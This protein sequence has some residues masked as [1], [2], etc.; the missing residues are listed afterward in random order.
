MATHTDDLAFVEK[1]ANGDREAAEL[2]L[3]RCQLWTGQ[4]ARMSGL[5]KQEWRDIANEALLTAIGQMRRGLFRGDSSFQTWVERVIRGKIAD[6]WRARGDYNNNGTLISIESGLN[7][8]QQEV[9]RNVSLIQSLALQK[10]D[11]ELR[12]RVQQALRSMSQQQ[13]I[14][15]LLNVREG[16]STDE[17]SRRLDLPQGTVGRKLAEAKKQ[18]RQ[19]FSYTPQSTAAK[20]T[21]GK[22]SPSNRQG[23]Q[24]EKSDSSRNSILS[25]VPLWLIPIWRWRSSMSVPRRNFTRP[26]PI[27]ASA[28]PMKTSGAW[29]KSI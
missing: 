11:Y 28:T 16:Y 22:T 15:L 17:I 13:A 26:S 9:E 2:F 19:F 12:I 8:Y 23:R 27:T 14:V 3:Y 5:P 7:E 24:S 4:L 6:Y 18:F 10:P 25:Q 1:V 29:S 21:E 20:T